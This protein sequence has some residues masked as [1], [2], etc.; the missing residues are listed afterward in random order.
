MITHSYIHNA[1]YK[2]RNPLKVD[3]SRTGF[4]VRRFSAAIRGRLRSVRKSVLALVVEEDA[5][6]LA[7]SNPSTNPLALNQRFRFLSSEEKLKQFQQYLQQQ[8]RAKVI[9]EA[10]E[11]A[12]WSTY[13]QEAYEKGQG[14][15]Y[16]DY[17]KKARKFEGVEGDF[18]RGS[19]AQFLQSSFARPVAIDK[20]KL[21]SSRVFTELKGI[22]E[23]M[24]TKLSRRLTDGIAQ[25]LNPRE[26]GRNIARDI[27]GISR[28]R[29]DRIART[30][31][32][33][34]H[35]EGQ[36]D[37]LEELG[38]TELGV[39]VEWSATGDDRTCPL[40]SDLDGITIKLKE[41]RGIIP[42]HPNCRCTWIPA[43]LGEGTE[44]QKKGATAKRAISSSIGKERSAKAKKAGVTIA[45]QRKKTS[46]AGA[47]VRVT[48]PSKSILDD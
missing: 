19:K 40:C 27:D 4:I 5:F 30:E 41:A 16:D 36:L 39:M 20:V 28:V 1:R 47:D 26:V 9:S 31:T 33:R 44:G 29:A 22:T 48:K 25:G 38:V 37:A 2:R 14:R 23:E 43:N 18:Y 32:I 7:E 46:W 15:A 13:V 42:R 35:A 12:Y 24:S 10:V 45:D 34:A 6:G 11:D 17:M 8:Y 21:L 3:P